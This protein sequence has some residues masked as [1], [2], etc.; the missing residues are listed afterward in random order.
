MHRGLQV[1]RTLR[2]WTPAGLLELS[3]GRK[4]RAAGSRVLN[5]LGGLVVL[6]VAPLPV[7][8]V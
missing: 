3:D 7:A 5:R 6:G 2:R 1:S 4:L 8:S